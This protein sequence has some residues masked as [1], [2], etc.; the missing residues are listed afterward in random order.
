VPTVSLG[1]AVAKV[2]GIHAGRAFSVSSAVTTTSGSV[3]VTCTAR[4]GGLI[5]HPR[6]SYARG[7]AICIGI[8]PAVSIG[9]RLT[10]TITATAGSKKDTET[11]S[12]VVRR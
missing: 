4:V 3:R 1:R 8:V 7:R 10:G 6:S 2:P 11:F 9:K 12:F 5:L